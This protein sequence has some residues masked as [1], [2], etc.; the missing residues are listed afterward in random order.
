[1]NVGRDGAAA[2]KAAFGTINTRLTMMIAEGFKARLV[3]A[4]VDA[5]VSWSR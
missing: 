3:H 2:V 4:C 1:M 5:H